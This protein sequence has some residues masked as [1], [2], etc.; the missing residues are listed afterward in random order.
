[1]PRLVNNLTGDGYDP[2]IEGAGTPVKTLNLLTQ[3]AE[4]SQEYTAESGT[5]CIVA[6]TAAVIDFTPPETLTAYRLVNALGLAPVTIVNNNAGDQ[7][8][9][10]VVFDAMDVIYYPGTGLMQVGNHGSVAHKLDGAVT[11]AANGTEQVLVSKV[12]PAGS[13]RDADSIRL[14]W[15]LTKSAATQ[16]ATIRVYGGPNGDA[17]DTVLFQYATDAASLSQ[18]FEAE[19]TRTEA[20]SLISSSVGSAMGF[21]GQSIYTNPS[22]TLADMDENDFYITITSQMGGAGTET[23]TIKSARMEIIR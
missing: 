9:K 23:V 21:A 14:R 7:L 5:I 4:M 1:M 6:L 17:T 8:L 19:F 20:T 10:T 13:L 11:S 2:Y 15:F 12:F 16:A 22:A 18:A 3:P